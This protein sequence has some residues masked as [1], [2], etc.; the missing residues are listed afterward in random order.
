MVQMPQGVA[1]LIDLMR[2]GRRVKFLF[3][4]GQHPERDGRVGRGS[5]SQWWPAP[6]VVDGRRFATAE[7]YMMWRK[8][9]LFDDHATAE[10]IL[11]VGHPRQAKELGRGVVGFDQCRWDAHRYEIVVAGGVAKFGQHPDLRRFLPAT[12]DRVLV[13]ASPLD[14]VWGI[15]LTADDP[16]AEDPARWRGLNLLGFALARARSILAESA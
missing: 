13:E 15:G 8:A 10:E 16:R 1:E 11:G 4:W 7:H 5:L 6:F 3:F 9:M 2:Q 12:K 14:C